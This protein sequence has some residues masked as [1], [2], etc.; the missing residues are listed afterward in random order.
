MRVGVGVKPGTSVDTVLEWVDSSLVDMVLIM[1]VE[2]GFGGQKF[3]VDMMSKVRTL[4]EKYPRLDIE[5][6]G[7]V[8][9]GTIDQCASAGA[10][11]IVS[12]TAVVKSEDPRSVM[13]NMRD[14]VQKY[15]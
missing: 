10:N 3:M 6:D 11:M 4:R 12:G 9:P 14:V 1:T 13:N 7:G 5:V 8:G 2:P 15:L